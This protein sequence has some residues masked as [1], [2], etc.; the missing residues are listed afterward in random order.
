VLTIGLTLGLAVVVIG[1]VLYR[2]PT[3]QLT[4]AA[5][6]TALGRLVRDG[7]VTVEAGF[8]STTGA[9]SRGQR[10]SAEARTLAVVRANGTI[11]VERLFAV[12]REHR[13]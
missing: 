5:I 7:A 3:P 13:G 10:D 6:A 12:M 2:S 4:N 8:V 1:L 11:R 9:D